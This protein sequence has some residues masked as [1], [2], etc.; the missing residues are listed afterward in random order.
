MNIIINLEVT[1]NKEKTNLIVFYDDFEN[2]AIIDLSVFKNEDF[3]KL[4]EINNFKQLLKEELEIIK[5]M[6][7]EMFET[8]LT[9]INTLLSLEENLLSKVTEINIETNEITAYYIENNPIIKKCPLSLKDCYAISDLDLSKIDTYFKKME[10]LKVYIDGNKNPVSITEYQNTVEAIN[11]MVFKIKKYNLSPIEQIMFAYD[12]VRDRV[13]IQEEKNEN[14]SVSRDLS[15][16]LSGNKIVCV[17]FANILDKV[18]K[19]LGINSDMVALNDRNKP[20]GHM[21][22]VVYVKD[23][24]Y[25]IESLYYLDPTWDSKENENDKSYLF[26]YKYFCRTKD[27]MNALS[28]LNGHHYIDKKFGKFNKDT[29]SE[30]KEIINTNGLKGIPKEMILI[31]NKLSRFFDG[32]QILSLLQIY[33]LPGIPEYLE[34]N[35][36]YDDLFENLYRYQNIVYNDGLQPETFLEILINVRKVEFYDNPDKYPYDINTI[37]KIIVMRKNGAERLMLLLF[38]TQHLNRKLSSERFKEL[39]KNNDLEKNIEQVKLAKVLRK[40]YE[41]LSD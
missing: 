6:N 34:A 18:L 3:E 19:N 14:T 26:S 11:K 41:N 12:L 10:N 2:N 20:T 24:K 36:D 27:E 33:N 30:L 35:F 32:K 1:E 17:G 4:I 16:V 37:K 25:K 5:S 13:Y 31:F 21:R 8:S 29:I 40:V 39:S 15:S 22:N 23:D 9:A 38:N 28:I 7:E